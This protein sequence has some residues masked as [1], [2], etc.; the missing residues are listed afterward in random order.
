MAEARNGAEGAEVARLLVEL[1]HYAEFSGENPYRARAYLKAAQSLG[2]LTIPLAEV[3]A[4]GRLREIPGVGPAIAQ[5]ILTL[6]RTGMHPQLE[7]MRAEIP[8]SAL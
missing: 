5:T 7:R 3:I 4:Q 2:A 8:A 1:G 6:F